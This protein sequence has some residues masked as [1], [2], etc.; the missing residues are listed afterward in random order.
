M[1][2]IYF[3]YFDLLGFKEFILNNNNDY[4]QQRMAHFFRDVEMSLVGNQTKKH[5]NIPIADVADI[6]KA[7]INC[8][9]ISDTV[10]YW[11]NDTSLE[12]L[13]ELFMVSYLF[14]WRFNLFN[15]PVRGCLTKGSLNHA[16]GEMISR[17]SSVY[18]VQ[19]PYGKV[20]VDAHTKAE[21]QNWA[22]TVID[23]PIVNDLSGTSWESIL[24]EYCSKYR[25]PY[26][27]SATNSGDI[28]YDEYVFRLAKGLNN[29]VALDRAKN[30]IATVFAQDNK[31]VSDPG[32]QKKI[33]NT[34]KYLESLKEF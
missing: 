15:F 8:I 34:Q 18:A 9:N 1:K 31:S 12:S 14:N 24:D 30:D 13:N 29:Q 33:E 16:M 26:K 7:K 10:L 17:N 11:T 6:D 4:I 19:C 2:E 3:A 32:V 27:K 23:R 21:A 20:M 22:G 25:V 5:P 28:G